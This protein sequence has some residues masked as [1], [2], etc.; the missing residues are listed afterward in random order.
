MQGQAKI[1]HCREYDISILRPKNSYCKHRNIVCMTSGF[2]DIDDWQ[3]RGVTYTFKVT[4]WLRNELN[5][6]FG[7]SDPK[8]PI[9][10]P[11]ITSVRSIV[12]EKNEHVWFAGHLE[13]HLEYLKT[14]RVCKVTPSYFLK[15]V[16]FGRDWHPWHICII[17]QPTGRV[18]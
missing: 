12:P 17:S 2:W 16:I 5:M 11:K 15:Q 4:W 10:D 7:F 3:F 1:V 6:F 13:R 14:A 8:N 9:L 18:F